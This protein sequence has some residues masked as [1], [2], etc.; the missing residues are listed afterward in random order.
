MLFTRSVLPD[1][2]WHWSCRG[3]RNTASFQVEIEIHVP[4]LTNV[5]TWWRKG[6]LITAG[7]RWEAQLPTRPL[8]RL[9]WLGRVVVSSSCSPYGSHW[10]HHGVALLSLDG[11]ECPNSLVGLLWYHP[12]SKGRE[13]EVPC[14]CWEW[15][16]CLPTWP[17]YNL[18]KWKSIFSLSLYLWKWGW[19][20]SFSCHIWLEKSNCCLKIFC[21]YKE[22]RFPLSWTF[23]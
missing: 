8:L 2:L 10:H 12:N 20:H 6:I 13:I 21:L 15:I 4:H 11:V 16:S 17:C 5:D 23:G 18:M 7:Q 14:Y 22:V 9:P 3:K 19:C 1:F